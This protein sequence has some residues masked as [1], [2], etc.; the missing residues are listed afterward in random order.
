[1]LEFDMVSVDA[2]IAN[3]L[4]RILLAEV[5]IYFLPFHYIL[6]FSRT[7]ANSNSHGKQK[8]S[9]SQQGWC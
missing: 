6:I 8:N 4:R 2:S 3:A 1:M 9:L 5:S 7:P